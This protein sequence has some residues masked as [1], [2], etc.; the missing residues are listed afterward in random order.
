MGSRRF[1]QKG[2][3]AGGVKEE[4]SVPLNVPLVKVPLVELKVALSMVVVGAQ[5]AEVLVC[6][7]GDGRVV[8]WSRLK[9]SSW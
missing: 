9:K 3:G 2:F 1:V 5:R 4:P 7:D 6:V 8:L